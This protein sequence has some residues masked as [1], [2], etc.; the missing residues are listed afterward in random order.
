MIWI[1]PAAY[2]K[3]DVIYWL[4][5]MGYMIL[6]SIGYVIR[7]NHA[8]VIVPW[9]AAAGLP[10]E[11]VIA[12]T[13]VDWVSAGFYVGDIW[14]RFYNGLRGRIGE[15]R[16]VGLWLKDK[17]GTIWLNGIDTELYDYAEKPIVYGMTETIEVNTVALE[18]REYM[19]KKWK[20]HTPDYVVISNADYQHVEFDGRGYNRVA[21]SSGGTFEVFKKV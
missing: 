2:L 13:V 20:T 17:E 15:A 10:I 16:E 8:L 4:P 19:V 1:L 6:A 18:R 12:L 3:P 11:F 7:P 9:I 5:V 21:A 14:N